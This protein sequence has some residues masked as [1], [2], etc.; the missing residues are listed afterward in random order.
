M[1]RKISPKEAVN[2]YLAERKSEVSKSSLQNYR[3]LLRRFV[4][5]CE[6]NDVDTL[7]Q[8]DG[9]DIHDFKI[10]R[11]DEDGISNLTLHKNMCNLRVFV[12]H[13]EAWNAVESG[14]SE[15]IIVPNIGDPSKD[16]SIDPETAK[17][18]LDYLR[19]YEYASF[20]HALFALLWD[21][22]MRVGAARSLDFSDVYLEEMYVDL[23]HRSVEGTPLKNGDGGERQVNLHAWVCDVLEDY[24]DQK[25]VD[26][27]DDFDRDPLFTTRQGRAHVNT[28]R[29]RVTQVT[30]PCLYTGECPH[31]RSQDDCEA[32]QSREHAAKCPS[33]VSPHDIRRSSITAWLNQGHRKELVSDRCDV[34]PKVLDKHYDVRSESDK[35]TARRDAFDMS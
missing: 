12:R 6:L 35:R 34:S 28:L 10:H 7:E 24:V 17:Q 32:Y 16:R 25:R 26:N 23:H 27:T 13:L 29:A 20:N 18:I 33:S 2:R 4:E 3:Y 5:W 30:Q 9:F 31:D 19:K 14:L 11:R 21:T 1:T 22:G 15:S 8:L